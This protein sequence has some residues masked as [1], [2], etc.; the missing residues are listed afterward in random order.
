VTYLHY[1]NELTPMVKHAVGVGTLVAN[2]KTFLAMVITNHDQRVS[3]QDAS[4]I[5]KGLEDKRARWAKDI[6]ACFK[7]GSHNTNVKYGDIVDRNSDWP[8]LFDLVNQLS[9][10][11]DK[12]NRKDLH[13][14]VT[15]ISHLVD[16]FMDL[17]KQGKIVQ[18]SPEMVFH[19]AEGAFQ[20]ASEIELF[21]TLYY[22]L[23][24]V[25]AMLE[26]TVSSITKILK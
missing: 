1:L 21:A 11:M 3:T 19:V 13:T 22:R 26:D 25:N 17:V 9:K 20:V 8:L 12:V 6:G 7:N 14:G 2:Y 15:D 18:G 4:A 23:M 5:Y 24:A 10:D 16:K